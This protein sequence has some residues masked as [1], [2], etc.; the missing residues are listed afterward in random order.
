ME[1]IREISVQTFIF[2]EMSFGE[3]HPQT[4]FTPWFHDFEKTHDKLYKL[5]KKS[6]PDKSMDKNLTQEFS[7][8]S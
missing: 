3:N 2:F 1:I 7:A 4:F 6:L 5:A 8:M